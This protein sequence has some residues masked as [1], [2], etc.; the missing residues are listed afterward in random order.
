M[1][2]SV[3]MGF[4][5]ALLSTPCSGAILA[6]VVI[7]AQTQSPAMSLLAF[8]LMGAG[9]ALPYAVITLIPGL[10]NKVPR[11][12]DWMEHIRKAMGFILL[13]IAVKLL[14]ALPKER[15]VDALFYAVI[16]GFCLWMWGSWVNFATPTGKK[17]TVRII[18]VLIAVLSGFWLLPAQKDVLNWKPYDATIIQRAVESQQP[19]VIKF[20]A[21]WC[22]NCVVVER[23]VY[24]DT[25]V[26]D[27]LKQKNVLIIKADT[28]TKDMPATGDLTEL[29]GES[30]TVP[31]SIILLPDGEQIKLRGIFDKQDLIDILQKFPGSG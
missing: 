1:T 17:W 15:L 21:D 6:A 10:L 7:W 12:G 5:A 29:Y 24:H 30:G 11:P 20:T 3:A 14:S 9:M 2:G 22:T 18:A 28:T 23:R 8:A 13:L 25:Q 27:L 4:F 19:V 16:L 26:A 31:V